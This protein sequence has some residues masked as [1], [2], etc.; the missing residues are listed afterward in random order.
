MTTEFRFQW[1]PQAD[2]MHTKGFC[3]PRSDG[4]CSA[5]AIAIF[6]LLAIQFLG[7]FMRLRQR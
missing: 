3:A 7:S 4:A 2:K 1:Q 6:L 5:N